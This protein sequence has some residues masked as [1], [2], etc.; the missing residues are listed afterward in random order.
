MKRSVGVV[1]LCLIGLSCGSSSKTAGVTFEEFTE[2]LEAMKEPFE[3]EC[4]DCAGQ[5]T[6][7]DDASGEEKACETCGGTGVVKGIQGPTLE[8]FRAAFGEPEEQE[9]RPGDLIWELWYFRCRE[10]RIRLPAF[11]DEPMGEPIR[12]V[13]GKPELE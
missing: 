2:R 11:L 4:A 10:G 5:G 8:A 3:R 13:T 1:C 6:V 9:R 12:V 7:M